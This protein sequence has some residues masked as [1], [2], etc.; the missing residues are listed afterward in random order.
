M[1]E[2]LKK[3]LASVVESN[4]E[5]SHEFIEIC[6]KSL[7]EGV[8]KQQEKTDNDLSNFILFLLPFLQEIHEWGGLPKRKKRFLELIL[9]TLPARRS[10]A[11]LNLNHKGQAPAVRDAGEWICT[12][13]KKEKEGEKD[14]QI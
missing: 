8:K 10:Y 9:Q 1:N 11:K 4:P 6:L 3:T 14:G 12:L 13:L 2:K 7:K 5:V